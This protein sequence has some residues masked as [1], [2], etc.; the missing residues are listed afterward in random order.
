[1]AHIGYP[2]VGDT[3]YGGRRVASLSDLPVTRQ[4]LHAHELGFL[5]PIT[6]LPLVFTTPLPPDI[7]SVC[8]A[9]RLAAP[10]TSP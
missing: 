5:H 7:E 4:M 1:M 3:V 6:G 9:L 2:V 10:K 8:R